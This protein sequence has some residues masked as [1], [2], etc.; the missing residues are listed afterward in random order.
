[1]PLSGKVGGGGWVIGIIW[2]IKQIGD[3]V[4]PLTAEPPPRICVFQNRKEVQKVI[5]RYVLYIMFFEE[6]V[7]VCSKQ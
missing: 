1:M 4:F 2:I 6:E 5:N 3:A 7:F